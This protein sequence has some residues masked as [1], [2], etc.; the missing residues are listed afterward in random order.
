[1]AE[2]LELGFVAAPAEP[3]EV[4]AGWQG[5]RFALA[6]ERPGMGTRIAI[7]VRADGSDRAEE[8]A[9]GAFALMDRLT[10]LLNR[11]DAGSALG[12]LNRHGALSDAPPELVRV[13]SR[14]LAAGR[15]TA[16]AF[17][18]TVAPLV[19]LFGGGAPRVPPGDLAAAWEHRPSDRALDP[20]LPD[21]EELREA[22]ALVGADRVR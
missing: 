5:D 4:E 19:D 9:H 8:A 21:P 10:G 2:L 17:D 7:S 15:H 3:R 14:A 11:Y 16:G 6:L 20:G 12:E 13:V 1:M 18:P 22:I